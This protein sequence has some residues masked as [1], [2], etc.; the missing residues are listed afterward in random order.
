[1]LK[2]CPTDQGTLWD[3]VRSSNSNQACG[4]ENESSIFAN[5][6][7]VFGEISVEQG[8]DSS[9]NV[10]GNYQSYVQNP[11]RPSMVCGQETTQTNKRFVCEQRVANEFGIYSREQK[12]GQNVKEGSFFH[13]LPFKLQKLNI[14][15][16]G[17]SEQADI[18]QAQ[19]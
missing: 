13:N 16:L 18:F 6:A 15:C 2:L 10:V 1:M 17:M 3:I 11:I 4:S 8:V 5:F 7:I 14:N 19:R 9:S 12:R